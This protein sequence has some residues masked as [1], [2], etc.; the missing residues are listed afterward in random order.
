MEYTHQL[1]NTVCIA[2]LGKWSAQ[3][4]HWPAVER[5]RGPALLLLSPIFLFAGW[6]AAPTWQCACDF[7]AASAAPSATT[8]P[9]AY[10]FT[11]ALIV[12]QSAKLGLSYSASPCCSR[13]LLHHHTGWCRC[14]QGCEPAG[15]CS[16]SSSNIC[17]LTATYQHSRGAAPLNHAQ[18]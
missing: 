10:A 4:A 9:R 15:P 3:P 8:P 5:S 6:A 7:S 1:P 12:S 18:P 2:V 13:S 14:Q 16:I 17:T 11:C